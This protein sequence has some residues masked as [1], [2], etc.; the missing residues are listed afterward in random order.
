MALVTLSSDLGFKG[1]KPPQDEQGNVHVSGGSRELSPVLPSNNESVVRT[2][3]N[4]AFDR[5]GATPARKYTNDQLILNRGSQFVAGGQLDQ[6]QPGVS[7]ELATNQSFELAKESTFDIDGKIPNQYTRNTS[8][9]GKGSKF[10]AG[11]SADDPNFQGSPQERAVNQDFTLSLQPNETG[12]FNYNLP[13]SDRASS[14]GTTRGSSFVVGDDSAASEGDF[15]ATF[16]PI[17]DLENQAINTNL[18]LA[19]ESNTNL[20]SNNQYGPSFTFRTQIADRQISSL[21]QDF[22]NPN[23]V[24]PENATFGTIGNLNLKGLKHYEGNGLGTIGNP[25]VTRENLPDDNSDP[26]EVN[27]IGLQARARRDD[28]TRLSRLLVTNDGREPAGNRFQANL[29]II[30]TQTGINAGQKAAAQAAEGGLRAGLAAGL[31]AAGSGV[32]NS[33][34]V[35]TGILA[36]TPVVGTGT[37]FIYAP[38]VNN[39]Y[40]QKSDD[41]SGLLSALG[42]ATG[43]GAGTGINGA[44]EAYLKG[45]VSEPGVVQL[46]EDSNSAP[47]P[48]VVRTKLYSQNKAYEG[49]LDVTS[50]ET[51]ELDSEGN[52]DDSELTQDIIPFNFAIFSPFSDNV[53]YIRLRAYLDT[54][55]DSYAGEWNGTKYIGRAENLYNYTGFNRTIDFSFRIAALSRD[56]LLPL[57]Y[58]LNQVVAS[59][60]PDYDETQSFMRG[61]FVKLTVGDYLKKVPGFFTQVNLSW[62]KEY[63]WEIKAGTNEAV[64]ASIYPSD[65]PLKGNPTV[66]YTNIVL[67]HVLDVNMSFQPVHN[68]NPNVDSRF[69]RTKTSNETLADVG[70]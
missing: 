40:L 42:A 60:A 36:Q 69:I 19:Q 51:L 34:K 8:L 7:Q 28:I 12:V 70:S 64:A 55:N 66:T 11:G 61:V 44:N 2:K 17:G 31:R 3:F 62:N 39:Q 41:T 54:F 35:V 22:L 46:K 67:P 48:I 63:P 9:P 33:G 59:T 32:L 58:K 56:E 37:H 13:Y 65:D 5:D 20:A 15:P 50:V 38:A 53:K 1:F 14:R 4:S 23:L 43:I 18:T 10:I 6:T 57:Y 49:S 30:A 52:F 45:K 26:Y 16:R 25:L 24:P 29:G 21:F 68:F 47:E 27:R